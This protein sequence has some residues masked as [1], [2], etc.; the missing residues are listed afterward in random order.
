MADEMFPYENYPYRIDLTDKK[1]KRVCWFE[2]KD[3]ADKFI[4]QHKLN[5]KNHT[6]T[7]RNG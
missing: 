7:I 1:D 6:L 3:H 5:K 2:C 4:K